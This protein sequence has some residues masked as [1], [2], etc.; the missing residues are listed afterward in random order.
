MSHA[1]MDDLTAAERDGL[2]RSHLAWSYM[3]G[4]KSRSSCEE[5][6]EAV[7]ELLESGQRLTGKHCLKPFL[8]FA[9]HPSSVGSDASALLSMITQV[10][11]IAGTTELTGLC[12][13]VVT[14]PVRALKQLT[15]NGANV[16][17]ANQAG[18]DTPL[19]T[20]ITI[21]SSE[22]VSVLL[23]AGANPHAGTKHQ[24][25]SALQHAVCYTPDDEGRVGE[26][27]TNRAVRAMGV[28]EMLLKEGMDP[29]A[30]NVPRFDRYNQP[31]SQRAVCFDTTERPLL[32]AVLRN[33]PGAVVRLCM[34][35]V[36]MDG[37]L[38][39]PERHMSRPSTCKMLE[40]LSQS[41][42]AAAVN[43]NMPHLGASALAHGVCSSDPTDHKPAI[44][45]A[46][47]APGCP[48]SPVRACGRACGRAAH[49]HA[50]T[51]C[52]NSLP[53]CVVCVSA[54][55]HGRPLRPRARRR[56]ATPNTVY[57]RNR[58]ICTPGKKAMGPLQPHNVLRLVQA[59]ETHHAAHCTTHRSAHRPL[60][61]AA[62]GV[63]PCV[64]LCNTEQLLQ[65][66]PRAVVAT[67]VQAC[68]GRLLHC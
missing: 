54:S 27:R 49:V 61:S 46:Q 52:T 26:L 65:C 33:R 45:P 56:R 9:K 36:Y 42:F 58:A 59:D 28:L 21:S 63:A 4:F 24:A 67:R 16:N 48:V 3:A 53:P 29:N 60:R 23:R 8:F 18:G 15:A 6:S 43:E 17:E 44:E 32:T 38:R 64:F 40:C 1:N 50:H 2:L 57:R 35:G 5:C 10:R 47:S 31:W 30:H 62:C 41:P 20:A 68:S 14:G 66:R 39:L 37:N 51:R 12:R 55:L 34:F 19:H 11:S 7:D 22:R 25:H 13:A